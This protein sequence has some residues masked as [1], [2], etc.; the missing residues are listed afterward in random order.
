[1]ARFA[2]KEARIAGVLS[3]AT[4]ALIVTLWAVLSNLQVVSSALLPT[5]QSVWFSFVDIVENGYKEIGRAHV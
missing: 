4:L 3:F 5:P 1:M 2:N